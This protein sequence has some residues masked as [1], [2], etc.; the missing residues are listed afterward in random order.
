[1]ANLTRS[2]KYGNGFT[3]TVNV[4]QN[5]KSVDGFW[6]NLQDP[7]SDQ[8]CCANHAHVQFRAGHYNATGHHIWYHQTHTPEMPHYI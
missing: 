8:V 3:A 6:M 2:S 7:K 5:V 4:C 1:M